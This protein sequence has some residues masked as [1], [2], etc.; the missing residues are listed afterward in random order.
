MAKSD[1]IARTEP[2]A[3]S[4]HCSDSKFSLAIRMYE[5]R[6]F[7]QC[8]VTLLLALAFADNALEG[9]TSPKELH[10]FSI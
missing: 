8:L 7:L 1:N 4:T 2:S 3:L 9:I 6:A 10:A 5:E